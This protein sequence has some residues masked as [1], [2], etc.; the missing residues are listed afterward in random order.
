[1]EVVL[2]NRGC[3]RIGESPRFGDRGGGGYMKSFGYLV[4][5]FG[6][7][8]H[9]ET[10]KRLTNNKKKKRKRRVMNDNVGC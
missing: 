2:E 4:K 9:Q 6:M 10:Y 5:L 8:C 3:P 7:E 1:M